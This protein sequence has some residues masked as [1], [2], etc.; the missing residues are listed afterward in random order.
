[1]SQVFLK[2]S[3]DFEE[4]GECDTRDWESQG[5]VIAPKVRPRG[6]TKVMR[7]SARPMVLKRTDEGSV[8]THQP[9]S[10]AAY[11]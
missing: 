3:L 5:V 7:F 9:T 11:A 4:F 1:M 2:L 10:L 6:P 8:R